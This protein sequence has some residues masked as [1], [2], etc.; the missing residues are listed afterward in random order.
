MVF[1]HASLPHPQQ[2]HRNNTENRQ[3]QHFGI[4]LVIT[5]LGALSQEHFKKKLNKSAE[6]TEYKG[7]HGVTFQ[8][9]KKQTLATLETLMFQ[10]DRALESPLTQY[11]FYHC[12]KSTGSPTKFNCCYAA[13][14]LSPSRIIL[15]QSDLQSFYR[16]NLTFNYLYYNT[17]LPI[18][19]VLKKETND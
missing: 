4:F 12:E 16:G 1:S 13:N 14:P 19:M 8:K 7:Y 11:Y 5:D 9:D 6:L 3:Q 2:T 10:E 18:G 15:H 17:S